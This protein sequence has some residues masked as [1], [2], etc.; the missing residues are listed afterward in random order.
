MPNVIESIFLGFIQGVKEFLP[1]SSS[2]HLLIAQELLGANGDGSLIFDISLHIATALAVIVFFRKDIIVLAQTFLKMVFKK[3][4]AV[5]H[6]DKT[7]VY[8]IIAGTIPAGLIGYLF[9]DSIEV[10]FRTPVMVAVA[11]IAGSIF[12]VI[13]EKVGKHNRELSLKRGFIVGCFQVLALAP[14]FSR[15]GATIGAG[16]LLGMSREESARFSF[17]LALPIILG[18]GLKSVMDISGGQAS[19][20]SWMPV[21]FGGLTAFVV[22]YVAIMFLMKY[23]QR[24]SLMVFV[25]YRVILA[26]LVLLFV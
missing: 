3:G 9:Q 13:A 21:L 1:V 17:L 15:S 18:A 8:A 5:D 16:V 2:G 25:W 22:G 10:I 11:L 14:G 24:N 6:K 26:A 20:L 12:F 4:R 7:M 19:T 23:L